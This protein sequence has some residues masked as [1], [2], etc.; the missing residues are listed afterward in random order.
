MR[1]TIYAAMPFTAVNWSAP[2][3]PAHEDPDQLDRALIP[4]G[5][6][7]GASALQESLGASAG[8]SPD[9]RD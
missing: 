5:T 7:H 9:D 2:A 4:E 1:P 6:A 3:P 8:Y